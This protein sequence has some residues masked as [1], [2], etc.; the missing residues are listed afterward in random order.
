M[1]EGLVKT[2]LSENVKWGL[3]WGVFMACFYSAFAVLILLTRGPQAFTSKG[4]SFTGMISV[5]IVGG[6]LAG[7]ILGM[8]RPITRHFL[9]AVVAAIPVSVPPSGGLL[10]AIRGAPLQ[11]SRNT[12]LALVVLTCIIAPIFGAA[13]W[14][15]RD[16][17]RR[18]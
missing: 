2:S 5:Y 1:R 9:G 6:I 3:G 11:W 18:R 4:A 7:G 14:Y 8:L 16:G 17:L 10:I 15:R 13:T 12:W